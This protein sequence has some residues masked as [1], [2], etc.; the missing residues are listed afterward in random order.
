MKYQ[1]TSYGAKDEHSSVQQ[2]HV[3]D[4]KCHTFGTIHLA[5]VGLTA[6]WL[7]GWQT[8][9]GWKSKSLKFPIG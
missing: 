9:C 2:F 1:R 8:K 3:L 4:M 5:L 6:G 7:A